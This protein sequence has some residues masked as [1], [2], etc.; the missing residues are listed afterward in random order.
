[1]I[2]GSELKQVVVVPAERTGGQAKDGGK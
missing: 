2:A 1:V